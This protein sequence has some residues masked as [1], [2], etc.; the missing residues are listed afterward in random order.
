MQESGLSDEGRRLQ[1]DAIV[2]LPEEKK[3]IIDSKVSLV[4]YERF[5]S[6]TDELEQAQHINQFVTSIR[7]HIKGLGDK[8]YTELYEKRALTSY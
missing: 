5:T 4:H 3:V 8:H 1:P 2:L 7:T 6:S